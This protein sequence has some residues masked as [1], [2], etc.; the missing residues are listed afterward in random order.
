MFEAAKTTIPTVFAKITVVGTQSGF[1]AGITD[2]EGV[3]AN[4]GA[5][6][7]VCKLKQAG[8]TVI[9]IGV[10]TFVRTGPIVISTTW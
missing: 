5:R 9:T 6:V 4:R 8:G 3:G 7:W 2:S 10:G 1:T